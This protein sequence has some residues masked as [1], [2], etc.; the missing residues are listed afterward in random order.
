MTDDRHSGVVGNLLQRLSEIAEGV[1]P[2]CAL[3]GEA[4]DGP[5]PDFDAGEKL[6]APHVPDSLARH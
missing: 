3:R 2:D 6:L 4:G 5:L 1:L